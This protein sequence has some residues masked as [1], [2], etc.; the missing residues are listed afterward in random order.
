MRRAFCVVRR[1]AM[2]YRRTWRSS[3][4]LS[5]LQPTLYLTAMG[6]GLGRLVDGGGAQ[7][8]GQVSYLRFLGPG[9]LAAWCMQTASFE[10]SFSI[11]GKMTER[12]NYEAMFAT[13]LRVI[14]LVT[15]ELAW[16]GVRLLSVAT[17]FAVVLSLFG[18][19]RASLALLSVPPAVL[20]GLAFSA[21]ML[22]YAGHIKAGGNFNVAFRFIIAPL[23]LFSGVFFPVTQL[24]VPLQWLATFTPLYHGVELTRGLALQTLTWPAAALHVLVLLAVVMLGI[25]AAV[26]TF[27]RKL[28][29]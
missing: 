22:A 24:P 20:T 27:A 9:L 26:W 23:F 14:D 6:I 19:V 10:S 17:I 15:G 29:A 1:N 12:R 25:R 7:L 8:P 2:V 21:P 13:P 5:F 3:L 4:F 28:Q 16:V 11:S 18:A